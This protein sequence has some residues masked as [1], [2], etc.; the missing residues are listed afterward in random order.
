M[1]QTP[2]QFQTSQTGVYAAGYEYLYII[3]PMFVS[4]QVSVD[5]LSASAPR[6]TNNTAIGRWWLNRSQPL[7]ARIALYDNS[8]SSEGSH[9]A[10]SAHKA[11]A[12]TSAEERST[13]AAEREAEARMHLP[14]YVEAR[15]VLLPA[16][17]YLRQAVDAAS[18]QQTLTG[19]LL[20]TVRGAL[21]T[22]FEQHPKL[23]TLQ[24]AEAYM[25]LGNVSYARV[26]EGIFERA[27]LYLRAA[28]T[29]PSFRLQRH[30][31]RSVA[32]P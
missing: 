24:A 14:D 21:V 4:L 2:E 23:T 5:R 7:L 29:I 3:L 9:S 30:L 27:V 22:L 28:S 11:G 31:R 32:I 6:L 18:A 10:S 25:S 26:G 1:I 13:D 19:D 16:T 17:E 8:S 12:S 20:V 15:G